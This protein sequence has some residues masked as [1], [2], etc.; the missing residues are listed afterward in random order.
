MLFAYPLT[1]SINNG[2]F[3]EILKIHIYDYESLISILYAAYNNYSWPVCCDN[4]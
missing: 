1:F 4:E 2:N 3:W